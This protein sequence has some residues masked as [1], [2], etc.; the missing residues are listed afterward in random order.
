MHA[1]LKDYKAGFVADQQA[2]APKP[3]AKE[4]AQPAA[5]AH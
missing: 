3:P 1:A 4:Q 2:A 5:A